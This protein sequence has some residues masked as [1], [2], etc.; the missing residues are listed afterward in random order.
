MNTRQHLRKIVAVAFAGAAV[1]VGVANAA[2][3]DLDPSFGDNGR[4]VTDF[5]GNY[6]EARGVAIEKDGKIVA[7]GRA[8]NSATASHEFALARYHRNGKLDNSFGDD[9]KV[10]THLPANTADASTAIANAVAV[11][12]NGDIV[13]AGS[14]QS[15]ATSRI[16]IAVLRYDNHGRLDHT[17]GD[18]GIVITNFNGGSS[19]AND[20]TLQPDG[21]IVVVGTALGDVA[22]ARFNPDGSLDSAF[23]DSGKVITNVTPDDVATAVHLTKDG[24]IL[25]AGQSCTLGSTCENDRRRDFL[26]LRYNADGSLDT[27]F[28]DQ[29]KV[30]TR[31]GICSVANDID[32]APDGKIVVTGTTNINPCSFIEGTEFIV[33]R[34]NPDGS[35]DTTFSNDGITGVRFTGARG[36]AIATAVAITWDGVTPKIVAGGYHRFGSACESSSGPVPCDFVLARFNWIG[37]LDTTFGV[38]GRVITDFY[39]RV[40]RALD[41]AIQRNGRIVQA[42]L[43]ALGTAGGVPGFQTSTSD[44]ALA[45]FLSDDCPLSFLNDDKLNGPKAP[46]PLK[47]AIGVADDFLGCGNPYL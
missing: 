7:A 13:A 24:K 1:L 30:I 43:T 40:D 23:G 27:S 44:F 14:F 38:S 8:F 46:P 29:G 12:Y 36:G 34:Y 35:L 45:R 32:V 31:I 10:T 41:L 4:V 2:D 20:M 18:Q 17:F 22:L 42:G 47:D 26:L 3:G 6:D 37:G 25:V 11:Q 19:G 9:G 33:A 21:K 39:G 15:A 28:G 16:D 5:F